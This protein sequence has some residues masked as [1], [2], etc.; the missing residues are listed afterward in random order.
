M[1][2][3]NWPDKDVPRC[4]R[5]VAIIASHLRRDESHPALLHCS[6]GIGRTGTCAAICLAVTRLST[7]RNVDVAQLLRVDGSLL[8]LISNLQ[9]I[10]AQRLQ[11]VQN[12][13]Q[14]KFITRAI[15]QWIMNTAVFRGLAAAHEATSEFASVYDAALDGDSNL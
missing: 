15:L 11:A 4:P 6:A 9:T 7:G 14:Y 12:R 2:W 10:R 8:L 13:Q 5:A 1:Q 3:T